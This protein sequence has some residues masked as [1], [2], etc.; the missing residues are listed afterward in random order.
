MLEYKMEEKD[1]IIRELN[2]NE[3]KLKRYWEDEKNRLLEDCFK[4]EKNK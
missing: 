4:L 3:E 2:Q 1:Q